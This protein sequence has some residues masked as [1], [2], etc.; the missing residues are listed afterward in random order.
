MFSVTLH[1]LISV[2]KAQE[3]MC[4]TVCLLY[5]PVIVTRAHC[6]SFVSI[7][8]LS[9]FLVFLFGIVFCLWSAGLKLI[10]TSFLRVPLD[11]EFTSSLAQTWKASKGCFYYTS[12]VFGLSDDLSSLPLQRLEVPMGLIPCWWALGKNSITQWSTNQGQSDF[13]FP[14]CYTCKVYFYFCLISAHV[15]NRTEIYAIQ[16]HGIDMLAS[17]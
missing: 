1:Q 2:S 17:D 11:G 14:T 8:F 12:L 15:W 3:D 16:V 13:Q 9:V 7:S 5:N 10:A 6:S 4:N